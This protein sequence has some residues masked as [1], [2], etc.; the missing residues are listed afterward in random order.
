MMKFDIKLIVVQVCH[1]DKIRPDVS[2][3]LCVTL[4]LKG[5]LG[6]VQVL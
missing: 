2:V 3:I 4:G 6:K 1:V 5:R